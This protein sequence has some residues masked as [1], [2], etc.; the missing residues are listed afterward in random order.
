MEVS[1]KERSLAVKKRLTLLLLLSLFLVLSACS[2]PTQ[3]PQAPADP[4][5]SSSAEESLPPE[6]EIRYPVVE[7][8]P[9][10]I[11]E[12][13]WEDYLAHM[14]QLKGLEESDLRSLNN[15]G[16]SRQAILDITDEEIAD[17]LRQWEERA[18][19]SRRIDA[20]QL[21]TSWDYTITDRYI[22]YWDSTATAGVELVERWYTAVQERDTASLWGLAELQG[23]RTAMFFR[24]NNDLCTLASY[25]ME[26]DS[27]QGTTVGITGVTKTETAYEMTDE[28]G[29]VLVIP[30]APM[31]QKGRRPEPITLGQALGIPTNKVVEFT[32]EI[33]GPT[34]GSQV[35]L[36]DSNAVDAAISLLSSTVYS[37]EGQE[38]DPVTGGGTYQRYTLILEGGEVYII[39]YNGMLTL[40]GEPIPY[41]YEAS[42]PL[43]L[44][45]DAQWV[46]YP[47][48][49]NKP[50]DGEENPVT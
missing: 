38:L 4:E 15:M 24:Q 28:T 23:R 42:M 14:K 33:I 19:Y 31:V 13:A 40:N 25:W 39:E 6:P 2:A 17:K 45:E 34:E 35:H 26:G 37:T 43:T 32:Y 46:T 5:T 44:P 50:F 12:F 36:V 18:E 49:P 7:Q 27:L 20:Q 29:T 3:E 8:F 22:A 41:R 10:S 1:G 9:T 47:I 21:L 30:T 16:Y 11:D 48:D